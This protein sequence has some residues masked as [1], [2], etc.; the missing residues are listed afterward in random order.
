MPM[1]PASETAA[2]SSGLL[3]GYMAPQIS[4]TSIPAWDVSLVSTTG[5]RDQGAREPGSRGARAPPPS[6]WLPDSP[7]PWL[8]LASRHTAPTLPPTSP[9]SPPFLPCPLPP[10]FQPPPRPHYAHPL[11]R[12]VPD[13]RADRIV[14]GLIHGRRGHS[15][16][17]GQEPPCLLQVLRG[18]RGGDPPHPGRQ[19]GEEREPAGDL[20]EVHQRNRVHR[21]QVLAH[22]TAVP[23]RH[24]G[25]TLAQF[26][27]LRADG[28]RVGRHEAEQPAEEPASAG[29][30][31]KPFPPN[32]KR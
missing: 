23:E 13:L 12:L 15:R 3:H 8:P 20:P 9:P 19:R 31:P 25:V 30:W 28:S 18:K 1:P 32:E 6:P 16:L 27:H 29:K 2:T 24:P 4:G 26:A 11:P 14:P 21:A 17:R 7:A 10:S 5:I 22:R